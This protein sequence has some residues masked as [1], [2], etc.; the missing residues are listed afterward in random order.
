MIDIIND[1]CGP[2]ELDSDKY[3][4]IE[5][6]NSAGDYFFE[7]TDSYDLSYCFML[8]G[9]MNASCY[10]SGTNN[11][12]ITGEDEGSTDIGIIAYTCDQCST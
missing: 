6:V 3:N 11:Y 9:T 5:Y 7:Y 12:E 2:I 1:I 8:D 10:I 4:A